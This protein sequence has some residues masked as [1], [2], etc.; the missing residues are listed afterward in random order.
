[1]KGDLDGIHPDSVDGTKFAEWTNWLGIKHNN[2][3]SQGSSREMVGREGMARGSS[4][5]DL[6][7]KLPGGMKKLE[8]IAKAPEAVSAS[9]TGLDVWARTSV[10]QDTAMRVYHEELPKLV[11]QLDAVAQKDGLFLRL[12]QDGADVADA[13]KTLLPTMDPVELRGYYKGLGIKEGYAEEMARKAES[14]RNRMIKAGYAE[15]NRIYLTYEKTNLDEVVGKFV[16]FHYWASR[17]LRFY[18]EEMLRNPRLM[19]GYARAVQGIERAQNDPG[20][21]GRQKKFLKLFEGPA[22]FTMLM[23]PE[24]LMGVIRA[25]GLD[26]DYEPDGQTK[27]GKIVD[28]MKNSP[29]PIGLYPWIDGALNMIGAYGD[30]F[31]PDMIGVRHRALVGSIVNWLRAESGEGPGDRWYADMNL[32]AREKVSGWVSSFAPGWMSQKVIKNEFGSPSEISLDKVIESRIVAKN[33]DMTYEELVRIMSDPDSPEYQSAWEDAARAG[34]LQQMMSFT[35]PVQMKAREKSGDVRDAQYNLI[36]DEADKLG[37]PFESISGATLGDAEFRA[38][39]ERQTGQEFKNTDW[40]NAKLERE[41]VRATPE[42]RNFIFMENQ[43]QNIGTPQERQVYQT[44]NNIKYGNVV[45]PG[46]RYDPVGMQPAQLELAANQWVQSQRG[47]AAT[48]E[49]MT[50]LQRAFKNTHPAFAQFKSWQGQM[51]DLSTFYG[52]SLS[53]YRNVVS[54]KNENA[55]RYFADRR[56][57]YE[58]QGLSGS[59]LEKRLDYDTTSSSAYLAIVGVPKDVYSPEIVQTQALGGPT[60]PTGT[61]SSGYGAQTGLMDQISPMMNM[62]GA[63]GIEQAQ[64]PQLNSDGTPMTLD[65]IMSSMPQ[66]PATFLGVAPGVDQAAVNWQAEL[67]RRR[68]SAGL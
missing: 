43:Y 18:S 29:I 45:A 39:Y 68:Q 14:L 53:E 16:P 55:A 65:D 20:L 1:M 56:R 4:T 8:F 49:K 63:T 7:K 10:L 41:L 21:D 32:E 37:I 11:A 12:E 13:V 25:S 42:S 67:D 26:S 9:G 35:L 30:T 33:P 48:V 58:R 44:Y 38:T 54:A 51:F 59:D 66:N 60:L 15:Q 61:T 5:R 22:G 19:A 28:W 31:E 50:T 23:N 52:G 40:A 27:I 2:L 47:G 36:K 46:Q 34:V 64:Q 62:A 17:K 3:V 57:Y 24:A 6:I